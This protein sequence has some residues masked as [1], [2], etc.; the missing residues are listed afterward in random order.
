MIIQDV[1]QIQQQ[2]ACAIADIRK[3]DYTLA[4]V[5]AEVLADRLQG[6]SDILQGLYAE[7]ENCRSEGTRA[8]IE[9]QMFVVTNAWLSSIDDEM[10]AINVKW[11]AIGSL[12]K[13]YRGYV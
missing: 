10:H 6:L 2:Y 8:V 12:E 11:A 13:A 9:K 1:F 3:I 5:L 4:D 7:A